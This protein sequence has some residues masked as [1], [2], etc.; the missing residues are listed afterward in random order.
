MD[1]T[2]QIAFVLLLLGTLAA[3]FVWE[4]APPDIVALTGFCLV[5]LF[6]ILDT[7]KAFSVFSNHAPI[8]IAAMFILTSALE[9]TG[10][11]DGV[12]R[13]LYRAAGHSLAAMIF[14]IALVAGIISAFMNNT[15]VVAIFMPVLIGLSRSQNIPASKLLIP[16]SFAA[17]MGGCCTLIGTST[18]IVVSN[19]A[20]Q[21]GLEPL[22][23]FELAWIGVPVLLI[24]IT[25]LSLFG[26]RFL[27]D[28]QSITSILSPEE[29]K[30]YFCQ[31]LVKKDSPLVG[32]K[33]IETDL[34]QQRADFRII[35]VRRNGATVLDALDQ[36]IVRPYDRILISA[37]GRQM[38][39]LPKMEGLSLD[40]GTQQHMGLESLSTIEGGIVEGVIAPHSSLIGKSIRSVNFRQKY[41]MLILA[42]HRQGRN[43]SKD[44][45]D[46]KMEFGDTL[47]MLGPLSTFSQLRKYGDFMLMEDMKSEVKRPEKIPWVLGVLAAVVLLSTIEILPIVAIATM[48]AI[49]LVLTKCLEPDEAYKAI[50][51]PIIMLIYGMLGVGA[52]MESSGTAS[53]LAYHAVEF[54]RSAVREDWLPYIMLSMCYLT[55]TLLTELLSNNATAVIL[56]PLFTAVAYS[57]GLEPRPFIIA[58]CIASSAA[59]MTP[60]GYQTNTMIYGPGGYKFRD[61]LVFGTPLNLIY[62]I[63]CSFL[64]PWIWPLR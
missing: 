20:K 59:F 7:E 3:A 28:R 16:L 62:W 24:G 31:V 47:L 63:L 40:A 44:F 33:L 14:W 11:I 61:F 38:V 32:K 51:W 19:M 53:W 6:G 48:G 30:N 9:K 8:T 34:A 57:L 2:W 22:G 4:W 13:L 25:Y 39:Q 41:A 45:L 18:N 54:I 37:S 36:I 10:S 52:A 58:V 35:E 46:I 15:P 12:G 27:P 23:M 21:A 43:L 5:I 64:I 60:I 42:V 1:F 56:V 29:R 26:P 17:V 55:T 50:D 49:L